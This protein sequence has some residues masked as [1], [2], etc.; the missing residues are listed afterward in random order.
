MTAACAIILHCDAAVPCSRLIQDIADYLNEYDDESDGSW[1]PA[2]PQLVS[3]ISRGVNHR[4]LLGMAAPPAEPCDWLA[5]DRQTLTRLGQRGHVVIS[6]PADPA[7]D[8]QLSHSFH[9]AIG[10]SGEILEKCHLFLN[11]RLMGQN[12]IAHVIGDVFLEWLHGDLRRSSKLHE[13]R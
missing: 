2:C 1:L 11:F 12:C 3:K 6:A 5:E 9:A 7:H 4:R 10:C 8:L 13:I